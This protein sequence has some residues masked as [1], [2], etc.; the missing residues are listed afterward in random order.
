RAR[1]FTVGW[2]GSPTTADYL[3][4]LATVLAD[5]TCRGKADVHLV[6]AG[7]FE[8]RG[9]PVSAF[10]WDEET[11]VARLARFDVGIV[12]LSRGP[13]EQAKSPYKLL[14]YMAM[15]LPVIATP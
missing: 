15:A 13:W 1:P 4:P 9:V 7:R 6:G 10:A 14:Q 5:L 8:L 3:R 11:E 12:P 2:I